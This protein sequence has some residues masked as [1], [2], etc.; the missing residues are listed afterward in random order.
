M[1]SSQTKGCF[2]I[3][4]C[5]LCLFIMSDT[6]ANNLIGSQAIVDAASDSDW[7]SVEQENLLYMEHARGTVV[8][9]LAP[10]FAP[11]V[12]ANIKQLIAEAYFDGLAIIRVQ[13]NYVVQWGDPLAGKEGARSLGKAKSKLEPEFFREREGLD[14][15]PL[16]SRDA[17]T[18]EVGFVD[19]FAVGS[20]GQR[21]WLTHCYGML[22]V[23]RDYAFDSGN[24]AELYVVT[25]HAPRHLD[26][27]VTLIGRVLSGVESL[28]SLPR[29]SGFLGFYES[30]AEHVKI[31]S[32]RIGDDIA[33]QRQRHFQVMRTD[34]QTF[35]DYVQSRTFRKE[36]WF[37]DEAGRIEICNVQVP[38]RELP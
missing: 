24:G 9:E 15:Q 14:I 11:N 29:G 12:I 5:L 25:G 22:G 19:G 30:E 8:F 16:E 38:V 4:F 37:A 23:G 35:R 32:M 18:E 3:S 28:S 2:T 21:A 26:R 10:A 33:A 36:S 6:S 17:Y 27:N 13:D 1:Y 31:S 20:D 34:S 7:R